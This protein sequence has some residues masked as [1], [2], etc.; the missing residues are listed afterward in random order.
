MLK[1]RFSYCFTAPKAALIRAGDALELVT[2]T[3]ALRA[4][5]APMPKAAHSPLLGQVP[6]VR[7]RYRQ[8]LDRAAPPFAGRAKWRSG[9]PSG[10]RS[11]GARREPPT[12]RDRNHLRLQIR[13]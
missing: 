3:G 6:L 5:D 4:P 9:R 11:S 7:F 8:T 10:P 12:P 2:S 1:I 13:S